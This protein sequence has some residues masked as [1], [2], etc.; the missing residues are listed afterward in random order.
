MKRQ[1]GAQGEETSETRVLGRGFR[2]AGEP[3]AQA[4]AVECGGCQHVVQ[5]RLGEAA[6]PR[7]TQ[8]ACAHTLG[9][10]AFDARAIG[11]HFHKIARLFAFACSTECFVG[12][13]PPDSDQASWVP[14]LRPHTARA[15][16]TP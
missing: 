9:D 16:R 10:R 1:L 13:L 8:S 7:S 11:V 14:L 12:W 6:V 4:E 3:A 5:M 15:T 2:R